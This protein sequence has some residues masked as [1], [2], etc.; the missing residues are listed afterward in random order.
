MTRQEHLRFCKTCVNREMDLKV[1]LICK[2]TGKI[3][4]FEGECPSYQEDEQALK[5]MDND[6]EMV[7][8]E[9][10]GRIS[11]ATLDK[12]KSEQSLPAA[13]FAG[14]FVGILAAMA[15]AFFTVSTGY[16]VGIVAIAVGAAV[17]IAMRFFGKG[18]DPIYGVFGAIIAVFSCFVGDLLSI[19]GLVADA[20]GFG[21]FE[22]LLMFDYSQ[23]FSIIAEVGSF[24]DL[25]FYAIAASEGYKF[26]FRKFTEKQLYELENNQQEH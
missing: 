21:F 9:I 25:V 5:T 13:I 18:L 19:I 11:K 2:L 12:L 15:W 24:M 8:N 4:D 6:V 23:T 14:I 16:K 17:G 7:R 3:A 20:E 22:T 10:T 1:G 26:S